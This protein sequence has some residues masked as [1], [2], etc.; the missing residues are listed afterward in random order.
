[1]H[2]LMNACRKSFTEKGS[3]KIHMRV[4]TGEKPY[5][6]QQCGK[7]FSQRGHLK[8]HMI[9]HTGRSSV[10]GASKQQYAKFTLHDFSPIFHSPTGFDESPT[11]ARDRRQIG[12]CSRA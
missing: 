9:I 1:M 4:H 2:E 5:T 10:E 8:V 7:G 12:A 6:C 11:N 3:P